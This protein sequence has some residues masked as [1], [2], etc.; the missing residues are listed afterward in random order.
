MHRRGIVASENIL[1][2]KRTN[3]PKPVPDA[4]A[5]GT[6]HSGLLANFSEYRPQNIQNDARWKLHENGLICS[7]WPDQPHYV[8]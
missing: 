2:P 6:V 7:R 1:W 5:L 4:T 8:T 3:H